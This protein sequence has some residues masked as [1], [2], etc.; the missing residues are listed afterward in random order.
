MSVNATADFLTNPLNDFEL[1]ALTGSNF[2]PLEILY[3]HLN[4]TENGSVN[5]VDWS[6]DYPF[7]GVYDGIDIAQF[8]EMA[9]ADDLPPLPP[10]ADNPLLAANITVTVPCYVVMKLTCND[11][12]LRFWDGHP[13]LKTAD[14]HKT[15]YRRLGH[16]DSTGNIHFGTSITDCRLVYFAVKSVKSAALNEDHPYNIYVQ[17]VQNNVVRTVVFKVIDPAIKNRGGDDDAL[18][19]QAQTQLTK[20]KGRRRAR[21]RAKKNRALQATSATAD[22]AT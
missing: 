12:T 15:Q 19:Q 9:I 18:V 8:I 1:G 22:D 6:L 21:R 13:A 2:Q 7:Y 5:P 16:V 3:Y 14:D 11:T 10:T 20:A 4:I 17:L